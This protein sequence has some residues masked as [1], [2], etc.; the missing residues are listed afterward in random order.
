M[1]GVQTCALP[2]YRFIKR[3]ILYDYFPTTTNEWEEKILVF[4]EAAGLNE[5]IQDPGEDYSV[6][7][8]TV[9]ELI[10]KASEKIIQKIEQAN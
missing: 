10:K 4:H 5:K 3:D 9:Y 8:R 7:I 2:I 6:D 1:T